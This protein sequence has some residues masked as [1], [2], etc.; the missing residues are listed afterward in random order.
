MFKLATIRYPVNYYPIKSGKV[1]SSTPLCSKHNYYYRAETCLPIKN[2]NLGEY[3][4]EY[5]YFEI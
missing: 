5:S 1:V 2:I 4:K 3:C